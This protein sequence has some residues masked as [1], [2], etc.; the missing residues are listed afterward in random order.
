MPSD[1]SELSGIIVAAMYKFVPL[2]DYRD[3]RLPLLDF[4]REHEIKGT[5]LLAEEGI[6]GTVAG[7]RAGIDAL[8]A[9]LRSDSRLADLEHKEAS[10]SAMPFYRMKVK[11]KKEIVTMGVPNVDPNRK[12]GIRVDPRQW[13]ELISDPD[14]LVIDTRNHYEFEIGSFVNAISPET[15][16]FT[17]FPGYV[18][19]NLDPERHKKIAMFCT[20]GIR[21][22]KASAYLLEQGF[23]EVYQLKGGILKYL[24]EVEKDQNLWSG[25]CFVFDGRVAVGEKLQ[26]GEYELCFSC[27]MPVAPED[28]KS[29]KFE[30]GVSC[31]RCYDSQTD[32]RRAR[33]RERQRQLQLA[34]QRN[35]QH[36]G[37]VLPVTTKFP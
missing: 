19:N 36:I 29:D 10:A 9:Y 12:S 31:P 7:K 30:Q 27:R 35:Y 16:A 18:K 2:P 17:E 13:N 23:K 8:L 1:N 24:E 11:L 33:L 26:P 34:T 37:A 5:L 28:R 15:D 32:E 6:N 20:G 4:C 22:E 3:L 14:V 21:C 25:E